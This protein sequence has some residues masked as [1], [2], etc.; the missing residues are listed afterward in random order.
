[1]TPEE[2]GWRHLAFDT[3]ALAV[4]EHHTGRADGRETAITVLAGSGT[5][6][7]GDL[8]AEFSRDSVFT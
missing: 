2:A 8:E 1:M 6:I 4:G 5:V 3:V 7:A